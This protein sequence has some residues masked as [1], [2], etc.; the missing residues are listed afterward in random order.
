MTINF[1]TNLEVRITDINYG[2]H[3]DH[4]KLIGLLHEARVRFLKECQ[5]SETSIKEDSALVMRNLDV[6]YI[7]QIFCGDVLI[8]NI[9][10]TQD[11]AKL[12]FSYEVFKES[13]KKICSQAVAQM[14][15][16]N[17]KSEKSCNPSKLMAEIENE[18]LHSKAN[19]K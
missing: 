17:K 19:V 3:L 10:L 16:I 13:D 11:K 8:I 14:V 5:M 18:Y 2:G 15:L 12:V 9:C 6:K 4:A 1:S 7:R